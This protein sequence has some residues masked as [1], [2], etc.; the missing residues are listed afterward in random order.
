ME[1]VITYYNQY[2]EAS[3]IT[4]DNARKLE[5]ITTIHTLD[6]SLPADAEILDLGAGTGVYS[7]Y[8]A[9]KG[10]AVVSTDITPKHVEIIQSRIE[11]SGLAN[12]SAEIADATDLSRYE[13]A[14]FDAVFCLGPMYHLKAAVDQNK[15]ISECMRVL[16]PGGILA[17]AYVNKLFLLPHLVRGNPAFMNEAWVTRILDE[18]MIHASDEDCFWTDACFHTPEEMEALMDEF[19]E[20]VKMTH[21]ATDGVGVLMHD[22]INAL[23]EEKYKAWVNYHLRTCA[24]PSILGISNHGMVLYRKNSGL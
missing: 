18:G 19:Q 8:Y 20:V 16:K 24:E 2:D 12:I 11:A 23:D 17:V 4:T 10:H 21:V 9:E 7:F 6:A 14:S 13:S 5:F 3:R 1:D 15:C 22:T